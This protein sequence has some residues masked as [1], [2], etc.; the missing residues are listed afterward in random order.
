MM[1]FLSLVESANTGRVAYSR[2]VLNL[3]IRGARSSYSHEILYGSEVAP[4]QLTQRLEGGHENLALWT[5]PQ[6]IADVVEEY[7]GRDSRIAGL[8]V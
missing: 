2:T 7:L 3:P 4:G 6:S 1:E 5:K 8:A